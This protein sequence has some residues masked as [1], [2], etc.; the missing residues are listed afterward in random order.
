MDIN[1]NLKQKKLHKN[2]KSEFESL[3]HPTLEYSSSL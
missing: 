1:N 3:I 2:V